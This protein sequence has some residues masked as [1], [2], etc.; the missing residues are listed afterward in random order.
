L[1]IIGELDEIN[2]VKFNAFN[3]VVLKVKSLYNDFRYLGSKI[4]SIF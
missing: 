3:A 2:I 4:S 1:V